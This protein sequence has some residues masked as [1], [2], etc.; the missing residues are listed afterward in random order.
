MA[1]VLFTNVRVI[2]GTG[3]QPYAAEVLIQGNRISRIT[4]GTR[5]APV[6][7]VAIIDGAGATAR[8]VQCARCGCPE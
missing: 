5:S 8:R 4:R 3:A 6:A 2:D 7:G 1:N